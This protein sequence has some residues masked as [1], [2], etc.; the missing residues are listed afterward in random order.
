MVCGST[1]RAGHFS[2]LPLLAPGDG[3][4]LWA[5]WDS[6]FTFDPARVSVIDLPRLAG[7]ALLQS[8]TGGVSGPP[9]SYPEVS[10]HDGRCGANRNVGDRGRSTS[11]KGRAGN[12]GPAPG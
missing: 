2:A 7:P 3:S 11:N 5:T 4:R 8:G 9:V 12:E 1:V 6:G 10:L